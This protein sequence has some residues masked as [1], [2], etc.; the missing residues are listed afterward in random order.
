MLG[1]TRELNLV[2]KIIR[3]VDLAAYRKRRRFYLERP[4]K[5]AGELSELPDLPGETERFLVSFSKIGDSSKITRI[6][7]YKRNALY[8]QRINRLW[9]LIEV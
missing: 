6:G 2:K 8:R 4:R 9:Q 5:I 3:A 7:F 1:A